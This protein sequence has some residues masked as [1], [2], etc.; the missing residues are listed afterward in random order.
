[1]IKNVRRKNIYPTKR[2]TCI[3]SEIH[4][5]SYVFLILYMSIVPVSV[6]LMSVFKPQISKKMI[7]KEHNNTGGYM[8]NLVIIYSPL[9][10]LYNTDV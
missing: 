2:P 8:D 3:L 4:N 9:V 6:P 10:G 7:Q 5:L 1:M